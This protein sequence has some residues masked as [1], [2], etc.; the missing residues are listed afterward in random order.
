VSTDGERDRFAD[1]QN[2]T[3]RS[4]LSSYSR[5]GDERYG[6]QTLDEAPFIRWAKKNRLTKN[7]F[8]LRTAKKT[9]LHS[10]AAC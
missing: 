4:S 6:S 10:G 1:V 3:Q 8:L 9:P 7:R 5:R 2:H